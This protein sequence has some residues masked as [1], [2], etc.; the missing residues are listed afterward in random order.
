MRKK[1]M[2]VVI[3]FS[4]LCLPVL[5]M[6]QTPTL[7]SPGPGKVP[8]KFV[9]QQAP[10]ILWD[11]PLSGSNT[12]AYVC[13][14][15][16]DFP[17]FSTF[18]ADDFLVSVPWLVEVIYVPGSLWNGGTSIMNAT[19]LHWQIYADAGGVP[20]GD[21][22]GGGNPPIWSLSLAPTDPQV[23]V[24]I[25]VGGYPSDVTLTLDNFILLPPG[26]YWLTFFPTMSFSSYGQYGR[27]VSDTTNGSIGKIINPGGGFGIGTTWQDMG[28][29]GPAQT[30]WAFRLEGTTA[31]VTMISPNGG[32]FIATGSTY[33]IIWGGPPIVES[34]RL[35]V[36][37]DGG[38]TW[39]LLADL[40]GD[41]TFDWKVPLG[42]KNK[43]KCLMSV[44]GF[45]G[46]RALVGKDT[47]DSMFTV[48]VV[49]LISPNGGETW[50]SG[51]SYG[52]LWTT[53]ETKGDVASVKLFYTLNGGTTWKPVT[54]PLA[55]NPGGYS[56]T[57]P[58]VS[59][60]K[61]KC[62]VKVVL[63]NSAGATIGSDVSDA[64]FTIQP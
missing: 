45:D 24:T 58:G 7:S 42:P 14:D 43:T 20:D 18:P 39:K 8:V 37:Y 21:P 1:V 15:F 41:N 40:Y 53:N 23:S 36:S 60:P 25:G 35:K 11:Q 6:A 13:Q 3:T 16:P 44:E 32:E 27:N 38:A 61:T 2:I 10:L 26:I 9:P 28:V 57:V 52:I 63:R 30:D 50:T 33:K 46:N 4:L 49:R 56:W 55:G 22:S 51:N 17:T 34:Y 54:T 31:D 48:E 12:N 47:S 62:K 5:L 64:L 19:A 59:A 29:I